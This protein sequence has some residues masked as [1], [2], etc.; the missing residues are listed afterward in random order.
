MTVGDDGGLPRIIGDGGELCGVV[1][2]GGAW[3]AQLLWHG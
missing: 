2:D 3:W 1:G